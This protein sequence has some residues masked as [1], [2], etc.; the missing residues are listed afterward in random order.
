[1]DTLTNFIKEVV[2]EICFD[3]LLA[4]SMVDTS[5]TID[6]EILEQ[7]VALNPICLFL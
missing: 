7:A 3:Q 4:I 6:L 1:M 5:H 2:D